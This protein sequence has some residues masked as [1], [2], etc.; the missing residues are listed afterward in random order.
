M[1]I[2]NVQVIDTFVNDHNF[3][4]QA[5]GA[6]LTCTRWDEVNKV[7]ACCGRVIDACRRT[8]HTRCRI[9]DAFGNVVWM[10]EAL[11]RVDAS[12]LSSIF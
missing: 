7:G 12:L 3:D 10:C 4:L 2:V 6:A 5:H 8:S 9:A 1:F 11:K